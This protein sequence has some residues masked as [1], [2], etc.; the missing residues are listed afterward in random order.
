M[1]EH[2]ILEASVPAPGNS[3]PSKPMPEPRGPVPAPCPQGGHSPARPS[4]TAGAA[5]PAV[6][7]GPPRNRYESRQ[8]ARRE[9]LLAASA[10]AEAEAGNLHA[11]ARSMS[12]VIPMGQPIL[13]GHH[14]ECE[15]PAENVG[16]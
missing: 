8:D 16:I 12:S 13:V 7:E 15:R 10:I 1:S 11:R 3:E 2:D 9:R 14:S 4:S 6:L 5:G